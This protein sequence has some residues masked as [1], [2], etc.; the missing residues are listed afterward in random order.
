MKKWTKVVATSLVVVVAIAAAG[1]KYRAY[2]L[3]PWTRDG[4]VRAQV[5]QITP[6]V[7]GPVVELPVRDNQ[8][9]KAGELLFR[10][11]PSTFQAALDQAEA[12]LDETRDH[13]AAL[14]KR[15]EAAQAAV[16][17][18][19]LAVKAREVDVSAYASRVLEANQEWERQ[20]KLEKDGATS[21]RNVEQARA[22]LFSYQE[23]QNLAEVGVANAE[24]ALSQAEANLAEAEATLGAEGDANAKLRAAKAAV[25]SAQLDL[26]F[27]EVRAPVDGDVTNLRLRLGSQAVAN[28]PAL[29]FVDINSFWIH[30][31]FRE[32]YVAQ[33]RPGD[34]A[35]VTLMSYP[36]TPLNGIVDS[37]GRGIAQQDGSTGEDLLPNVSPTFEWIRLAQRVPIR[38]HLT[39]VPSD[40]DLIVGTTASVLVMTGTAG[41][42]ETAQAP[43]APS[44]L[45]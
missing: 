24:A 27:T 37:I 36:D 16:D 23:R 4:Q 34:K 32:S 5:I 13:I 38:V 43:P 28:Q 21:T 44:V 19:T 22:T 17:A 42:D 33:V 3:N 41:S 14:E 18:A 31:F 6:R 11:D 12:N 30:G 20:L 10:I 29:A 15:V 2:V 26:K 40:I 39:D 8:R 1:Y 35:V 7:S 9:V 25:R 45:Q